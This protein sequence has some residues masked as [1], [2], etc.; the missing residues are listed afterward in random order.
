MPF[1]LTKPSQDENHK[2][3]NLR[4]KMNILEMNEILGMLNKKNILM[5]HDLQIMLKQH[6]FRCFRNHNT[7]MKSI[8]IMRKINRW[9]KNTTMPIWKFKNT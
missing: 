7:L 9:L 6:S 5:T 4:N 3:I 1:L 8:S 2:G